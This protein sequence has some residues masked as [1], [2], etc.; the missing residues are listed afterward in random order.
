MAHRFRTAGVT[1]AALATFLVLSGCSDKDDDKY[2]APAAAQTTSAAAIASSS[3]PAAGGAVKLS[4]AKSATLGDVVVDAQGFTLY[5]FDKD[6]NDPPKSNC[7]GGCLGTW[8]R[9]LSKGKPDASGIDASLLGSFTAADG[10][11]QVTMGGWPLYRYAPDAKPGDTTGQGV[12]GIWWAVTP[13]GD[14]ATTP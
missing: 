14:K 7:T 2:D 12:G 9:S 4:V 6:S 10:G 11:E 3:A 1:A 13:K 8:P 5:R